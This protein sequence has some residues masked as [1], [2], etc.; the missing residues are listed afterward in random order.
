M[1][2]IFVLNNVY[3]YHSSENKWCPSLHF[4]HLHLSLPCSK[5][6]SLESLYGTKVFFLLSSPR[7]LITLP[8]DRRPRLML[9][10]IEKNQIAE[11]KHFLVQNSQ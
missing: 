9:M 1:N 11:L 4:H 3:L 2:C 10:P 5:R 7:A 6:V 8:N